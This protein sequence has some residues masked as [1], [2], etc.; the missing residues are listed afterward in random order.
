MQDKNTHS[1][2]P[3][4]A[5]VVFVSLH[6]AYMMHRHGA[7]TGCH[8]KESIRQQYSPRLAHRTHT[9]IMYVKQVQ[10]LIT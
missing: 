3:T 4:E 7:Y 2:K 10:T 6:D 8:N 9:N 1:I 5:A